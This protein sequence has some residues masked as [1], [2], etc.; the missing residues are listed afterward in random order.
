MSDVRSPTSDVFLKGR[1][2]LDASATVMF[3]PM[4]PDAIGRDDDERVEHTQRKQKRSK[5][6]GGEVKHWSYG[7][8]E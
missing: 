2:D 7:V 5:I 8:L 4:P 1:P 6:E 3:A